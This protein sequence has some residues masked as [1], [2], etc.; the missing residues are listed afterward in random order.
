[1]NICLIEPFYGGS[2]KYWADNL[3]KWSKHNFTVFTLSAKHWKWRMQGSALEINSQIIKSNIPVPDLFI[4]SDLIDLSFFKSL[5]PEKYSRVK[6]LFYMHENQLTYPKSMLDKEKEFDLSYGYLN[7]KS[8]LVADFILFNS[9]F[10]KSVFLN[11]AKELLSKM[12][13]YNHL[14]SVDIIESKSDVLY[15]G[16]DMNFI[17]SIL[18]KKPYIK[19]PMPT[20]LWNHRWK[21]DKNPQGFL[22]LLRNLKA[23]KVDFKLKLTNVESESKI[24]QTINKEF[25]NEIVFNG[26]LDSYSEYIKEISDCDLIPMTSNHDFFGLS[27]MEAVYCGVYPILPSNMVYEEIYKDCGFS[28]YNDEAELLQLTIDRINS[29]TTLNHEK[30]RNILKKYD[31]NSVIADFDERVH[32]L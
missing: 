2:H 5:L 27:L 21:A 24:Y 22:K 20:L 3:V 13:D 23:E 17:N 28:Y 16:I 7:F 25:N 11:A 30:I 9:H 32:T 18:L 1:M 12:P 8:C 15:L 6:I 14:A 31:W 19:N 10:H 4:V 29:K 26:K